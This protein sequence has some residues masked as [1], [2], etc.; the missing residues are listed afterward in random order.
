MGSYPFHWH[1][2]GNANG[3]YLRDS[4]VEKSFQRCVVLHGTND[5]SVSNNVCYDHFGHGFFLED[6]SEIRNEF[7]YNIGILSKKIRLA[8]FVCL[9]V[10]FGSFV[11]V[12]LFV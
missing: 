2:T 5:V 10:V 4:V 1:L 9:F 6:G 11:F 3:Q 8:L 12:C 7:K